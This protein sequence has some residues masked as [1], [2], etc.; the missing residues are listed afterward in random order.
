M[1]EYI[2]EVLVVG[3]GPAGITTAL[4][5]SRANFKT[6]ILGKKDGAICKSKIENIF[7]VS[8][9]VN[10]E[11]LVNNSLENLKRLNVEI[12]EEYAVKFNLDSNII[13]VFTENNKVIKT[14][15]LVLA[16]GKNYDNSYSK[17]IGK[18]LSF[19]VTCDGFFY[20]DKVVGMLAKNNEYM[21]ELN[22]LSKIC[23]KVYLF[24]GNINQMQENIEKIDGDIKSINLEN[25]KIKSIT[26]SKNEEIDL[27]GLFVIDNVGLNTMSS[28]G[29]ITKDNHI[30]VDDNY[31]T[32]IPNIYA[33]GDIIGTPYQVA[34]ACYDGMKCGLA[35]IKN[36]NK[37]ESIQ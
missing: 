36:L 13:T 18:G 9:V 19:C 25:D 21:E 27:D 4:Y 10:G 28:L 30:L 2:C 35:I 16:F 32:N 33:V 3:L 37:K 6:I 8:N 22:I 7:G 11:E 1:K 24:N 34:K 20:K 5:T 12:F 15:V 17:Y 29:I 14:K 26:T 23:S 31:Q